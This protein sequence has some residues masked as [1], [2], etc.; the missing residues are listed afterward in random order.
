MKFVWFCS[1]LCHQKG[2]LRFRVPDLSQSLNATRDG[3]FW[4]I[5]LFNCWVFREAYEKSGLIMIGAVSLTLYA[6]MTG[7]AA[8]SFVVG[9]LCAFV[10]YYRSKHL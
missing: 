4:S 9:L 1:T 5:S 2:R 3:L 10:G 7:I 8:F 6:G